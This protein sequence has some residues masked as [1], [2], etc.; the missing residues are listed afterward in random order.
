[1]LYAYTQGWQR[2]VYIYMYINN[3]DNNKTWYTAG[4]F[5]P[6]LTLSLSLPLDFSLFPQIGRAY[7]S[8][9]LLP[10]RDPLLNL[11]LYFL[12]YLSLSLCLILSASYILTLYDDK[13]PYTYIYIYMRGS[14]TA[15]TSTCNSYYGL[16]G[17]RRARSGV[18]SEPRT[19]WYYSSSSPG[20]LSDIAGEKK[21]KRFA[22]SWK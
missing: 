13:D 16:R 4:T 15:Q 1:M 2:T 12:F 3:N 6:F 14:S 9:G 17:G 20:P 19:L 7:V 18:P 21:K 8:S 5:C 11:S 22:E 10:Y